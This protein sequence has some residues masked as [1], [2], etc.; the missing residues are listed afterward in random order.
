MRFDNPKDEKILRA[1]RANY[2]HT[3]AHYSDEI[4]ILGVWYP[5]H[6]PRD[7][8]LTREREENDG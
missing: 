3:S 7:S 8:Y 1:I 2:I 4:K 6:H 5:P